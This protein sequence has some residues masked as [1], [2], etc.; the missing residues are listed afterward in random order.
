MVA[1]DQSIAK[2]HARGTDK[3]HIDGWCGFESYDRRNANIV[4]LDRRHDMLDAALDGVPP[5][6]ASETIG[7]ISARQG[8]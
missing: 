2:F 5:D 8:V 6:L 7:R 4:T 3:Y 1:S